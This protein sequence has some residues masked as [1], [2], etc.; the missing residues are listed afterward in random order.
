MLSI[1]TLHKQQMSRSDGAAHFCNQDLRQEAV[2]PLEH[3]GDVNSSGVSY[4]STVNIGHVRIDCQDS[5]RAAKQIGAARVA[6]AGATS[7][8]TGI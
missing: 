4:S 7:S 3:F 2:D 6:K 1:L 5:I 8:T